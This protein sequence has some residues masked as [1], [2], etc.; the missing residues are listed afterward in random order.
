MAQKKLE[1]SKKTEW[2]SKEW[3]AIYKSNRIRGRRIWGAERKVGTTKLIDS[4]TNIVCIATS[5]VP[6]SDALTREG[7]NVKDGFFIIII[8]I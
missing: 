4:Y 1:I 8:Y 2:E 7:C 3:D 5:I 6:F